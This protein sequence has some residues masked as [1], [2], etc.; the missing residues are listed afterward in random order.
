MLMVC[1]IQ[2]HGGM[3]QL[4]SRRP[5]A[6][7]APNEVP[8]VV[9]RSMDTA[10]S[11]VIV[12][13]STANPAGSPDETNPT[14]EVTPSNPN[15]PAHPVTSDIPAPELKV[16]E[17]TP[18]TSPPV[19]QQRPNFMALPS[20]QRFDFPPTDLPGH[21]VAGTGAGA[22]PPAAPATNVL[23]VLVVD[24]DP[25][26]RK[27]MTRMLTRL[28]CVCETAENGLIALGAFLAVLVV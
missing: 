11:N 21:Q 5:R 15:D 1:T 2:E 8:I 17:P 26:T 7:A 20:R 23:N 14:A 3:V 10:D 9:T 22:A 4:A 27:L 12:N 13:A 24:D 16:T 28:G 18:P 25:L 6:A 19:Q